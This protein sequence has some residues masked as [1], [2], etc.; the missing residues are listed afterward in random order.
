MIDFDYV[1]EIDE[2]D[3]VKKFTPRMKK[4]IKN[5]SFITGKNSS[6]KSTL[7]NIIAAAFYG[8]QLNTVNTALKRDIND[9]INSNHKRLKFE[10]TITDPR[11]DIKLKVSKSDYA[12]KPR[13]MESQNGGE[14]R[15]LP[16]FEFEKKY[17][18]I[19]DIPDNPRTRLK[20][21]SKQLDEVYRDYGNELYQFSKDLA[22][23]IKDIG[24]SSKKDDIKRLTE[25]IEAMKKDIEYS[26]GR[27]P[28]LERDSEKIAQV[29]TLRKIVNAQIEEKEAH[30][31]LEKV[32]STI[33]DYKFDDKAMDKYINE[34]KDVEYKV[35]EIKNTIFKI[36]SLIMDIAEPI[37]LLVVQNFKNIG[38]DCIYKDM[39]MPKESLLP[40]IN[41]MQKVAEKYSHSSN[42]DELM[43]NDLL[44]KLLRT[45]QE[46]KNCDLN[47]PGLGSVDDFI[48][49]IE[50]EF[51][52]SARLSKKTKNSKD[53]ANLCEDLKI[54][55]MQLEN[56]LEKII[57]PSEGGTSEKNKRIFDKAEADYKVKKE[58]TNNR[59]KDASPFGVTLSNYNA[60]IAELRTTHSK[61]FIMN[62][63]DLEDELDNANGLVAKA[64]NISDTEKTTLPFKEKRLNEMVK[65]QDH[66]MT[67]KLG[68]LK[69]LESAVNNTRKIIADCGKN[70][71]K[72]EA[73]D[74]SIKSDD[75][76][77][78]LLWSYL[79]K[80]I[81][82]ITHRDATYP[83]STVNTIDN[84]ITTNTGK[85]IRINDM[86]TGQT[87]VAYLK[88]LLGN[89]DGRKVIALFDEVSTMDRNT[90]DALFDYF[91][92][93]QKEGSLL[94]GMTVQPS[95]MDIF[96][97]EMGL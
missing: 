87:Q 18:L 25:E 28:S 55:L 94:M 40:A 88:S 61:Y 79:G 37:D 75:P 90:L 67:S 74:A 47:V 91:I 97:E 76:Y 42:Q 16:K 73:G 52:K 17:N 12:S 45:L 33:G 23:L 21:V 84:I 96:V 65:N 20:D 78:M 69:E 63:S 77:A 57:K 29:L 48:K 27:L 31:H 41:A 85:I 68:K 70:Q 95:E 6:G 2:G 59:F 92:K 26:K 32:K 81:G 93:M 62:I 89:D 8:D 86:G 58:A 80:R 53:A 44:S 34:C 4:S 9:L 10:L 49:T 51:N 22:D 13:V 36:A 54:K 1:L 35:N 19:Y 24:K 56:K 46:Y 11:S 14:Y 66:P 15:D 39:A 50:V 43:K 5:I 3:E 60:K 71:K 72:I 7:M 83:V 82:S 38:V 30:N 64:K